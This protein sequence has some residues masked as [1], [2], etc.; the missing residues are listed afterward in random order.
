MISG[1][2]AAGKSTVAQEIIKS[3]SYP[4]VYIEGDKFW[5]FIV[6]G[7]ESMGRVKNFKTIM[8]SMT[9]AAL[10]YA[11]SGYE[12]ILDFSIPPWFLATAFKITSKR[13]VPLEYIV[14]RPG[15]KIC[16]ARAATRAEGKITDYAPYHD[17]YLSF[18]EAKQYTIHDD[19]SGAAV[20]AEQIRKNITEG[21]YRISK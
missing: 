10:P 5:G 9:V 3:S 19:T 1:P 4:V 13:Q 20:I 15:E 11:L 7:F 14:L 2:V 21:L 18:D 6:K 17:L 16:T 8:A 12:V